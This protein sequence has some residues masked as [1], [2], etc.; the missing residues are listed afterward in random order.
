LSGAVAGG[1]GTAL[2]AVFLALFLATAGDNFF[3]VAKLALIAHVPVVIIETL[4]TAVVVGFLFRVKP[5]LLPLSHSRK[6]P[7]MP[8]KTQEN[9]AEGSESPS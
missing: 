9:P 6:A 5:D 7:A 8:T 1:L 3:A 4:V 2:A